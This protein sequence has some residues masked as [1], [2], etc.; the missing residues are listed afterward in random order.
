MGVDLLP[1]DI[2]KSFVKFSVERDGEQ[3]AIR[4]ALAAIKNVGEGAMAALVNAREQ[5]G[6]FT[7][8]SDFAHRLDPKVINKRQMES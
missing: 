4:Y 3:S 5:D 8:V 6:P 2:N 1:P 7:D